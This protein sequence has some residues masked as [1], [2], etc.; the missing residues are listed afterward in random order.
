MGKS[1]DLATGASYVDTSGDTMS[2]DLTIDTNTF[3]VDV[4]DNRVG[5]GTTAPTNQLTITD[6]TATPY[7][8]E[9][10]VLLDL[11]RATT[12]TAA[13]KATAIRL[14]NNSNGARLS[15]GGASDTMNMIMGSGNIT[16]TFRND[17]GMTLPY[18][19]SFGARVL[20]SG[21]T[22]QNCVFT[23]T[24]HNVGNHYSTSTGRFTCPVAG[25]Y[26]FGWTNIG[27]N[28]NDVYRYYIR[29]NGSPSI[30]GT[31]GDTH[32]R[33]DTSATGSEYGTN[34]MYTWPVQLSANDYVSIYYYADSGTGSH[35]SGD[36]AQFWGHLLG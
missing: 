33:I 3:H 6:G 31:S 23:T 9:D 22:Q 10:E 12:N 32:L 29:V 15:Y 21:S 18:Q 36:Y 30:T 20:S 11:K 13:N 17:G 16:A 34:A 4:A 5:I 19:P 14:G 7:G 1:K 26:L 2:G 35:T 8:A 24:R 28:V 25:T 27:G